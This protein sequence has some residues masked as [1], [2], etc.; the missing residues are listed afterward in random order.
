MKI[1]MNETRQAILKVLAESDKA[2]TLAEISE[3]VGK[4]VSSGTTNPL[5]TENYLKAEDVEI[6]YNKVRVDNGAVIGQGHCTVKAYT[7]GETKAE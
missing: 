6:T 7:L 1:T 2:L 4:K 3:R 5:V